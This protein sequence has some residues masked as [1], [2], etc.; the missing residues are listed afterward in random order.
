MERKHVGKILDDIQKFRIKKNWYDYISLTSWDNDC[1]IKYRSEE[2]FLILENNFNLKKK[3]NWTYTCMHT[4]QYPRMGSR[5]LITQFLR[6]SEGK[7]KK[8]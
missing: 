1:Q 8:N 4:C 6:F 3:R 2:S 7:G 5:E